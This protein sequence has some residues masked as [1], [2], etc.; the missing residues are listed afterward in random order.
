MARPFAAVVA[1][2]ANLRIAPHQG[3]AE[4]ERDDAL[5]ALVDPAL[6]LAG[7]EPHYFAPLDRHVPRLGLERDGPLLDDEQFLLALVAVVTSSSP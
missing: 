3:C 4:C 2:P 7:R 5:V 6:E 1:L